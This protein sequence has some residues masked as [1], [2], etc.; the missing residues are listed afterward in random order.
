MSEK[1]AR[2]SPPR[3]SSSSRCP[4]RTIS[5]YRVAAKKNDL[6]EDDVLTVKWIEEDLRSPRSYSPTLRHL[7]TRQNS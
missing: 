3:T 7:D 5:G 4:D 1:S 2:R 6:M